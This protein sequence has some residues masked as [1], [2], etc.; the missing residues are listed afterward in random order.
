MRPIAFAT[1]VLMLAGLAGCGT[2]TTAPPAT[3]AGSGSATATSGP[4]TPTVIWAVQSG[5]SDSYQAGVDRWKANHP[6]QPIELQIMPDADYK[7]KIRVALGAGEGP[8][9]IFNWGGGGLKDFVDAG[10]VD[11]LDEY[12]SQYADLFTK[13]LDATMTPVKFS[14][15]TYGVPIANM[16]P[17]VVYYNGPVFA[18]ASAKPAATWDDFLGLVST[19]KGQGIAPLTV[20]GQSQWPYL[21]YIAYLVD[22]IG[23]PEVFNKIA[24]NTAGSWNDPAVIQALT[25]I[26]DLVKAGGLTETYS[27][28]AYETGAADALLY[29]DKA[30]MLVMLASAYANINK[31]APDFVA[32]GSL[33]Y[34]TFPTVAG[35]KGDA[36]DIVG[37]PSNYWSLNAKATAAHKATAVQFLAEEVENDQ[38]ASE[39]IGR[40][41]IP[42]T[43]SAEAMLAADPSKEFAGYSFGLVKNAKNFQMSWDQALSAEQGSALKTQLEQIFLLA[44]TPQQFVDEM[45]KTITA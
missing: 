17:V 32:A 39:I 25:M 42:P 45:N 35:G 21:P 43:V 27:S 5:Q 13:Y 6:D 38:W 19:F 20:A 9:L 36:S 41:G 16:Q 37:N 34:T 14:G 8:D 44:I 1:S 29:T 2:D 31:A 26:Q 3:T 40:N 4:A 28:L 23:G 18:A 7:A 12:V 30:A 11:P 33:K 15:K 24:A 10:Y 22:R